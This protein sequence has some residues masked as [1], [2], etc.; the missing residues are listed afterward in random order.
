MREVEI[1]RDMLYFC[2]SGPELILQL[3]KRDAP[4]QNGIFVLSPCTTA[5][6]PSHNDRNGGRPADSRNS[7]RLS[8]GSVLKRE[9]PCNHDGHRSWRWRGTHGGRLHVATQRAS[10]DCHCCCCWLATGTSRIH[11]GHFTSRLTRRFAINFTGE[12]SL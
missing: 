7:F 10:R 4:A 6:R 11:H 3:S 12:F 8:A 9:L 1:P 5:M 2:R